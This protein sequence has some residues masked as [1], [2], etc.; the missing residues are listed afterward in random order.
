MTVVF[1]CIPFHEAIF[2]DRARVARCLSRGTISSPWTGFAQPYS[3]AF[4]FSR[5]T[6]N[7][8]RCP[9]VR[10]NFSFGTSK[11]VLKRCRGNLHMEEISWAVFAMCQ[12]SLIGVFPKRTRV[13]KGGGTAVSTY[14]ALVALYRLVGYCVPSML[15]RFA[16]RFSFSVRVGSWRTNLAFSDPGSPPCTFWLVVQQH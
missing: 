14:R 4:N 9:F 5:W 6:L 2:T 3:N 11:T 10:C 15:T 7:T 12:A 1:C 16:I 13:A 8:R